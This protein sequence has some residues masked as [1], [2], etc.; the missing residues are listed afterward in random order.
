LRSEDLFEGGAMVGARRG[1]WT[2]AVIGALLVPMVCAAGPI[3]ASH[4]AGATVAPHDCTTNVVGAVDAAGQSATEDVTPTSDDGRYMA[5]VPR[6]N[7]A[8]GS[9]IAVI[10]RQTSQL[11]V[12][13]P[14]QPGTHAYVD[15][16]SG[17]GRFVLF[18]TIATDPI[19]GTDT[20]AMNLS[21]ADRTNH[22]VTPVAS[23]PDA[24]S[25]P[26]VYGAP[27]VSDDGSTVVLETWRSLLPVDTDQS[28]DVYRWRRGVGLDLVSTELDGMQSS[29]IAWWSTMSDD[30]RTIAFEWT[31]STP[32]NKVRVL[33]NG[34]T[35]SYTQV[36]GAAP[37][38]SGDGS[39]LFVKRSGSTVW[40]D[41]TTYDPPLPGQTPEHPAHDVGPNPGTW[42][43]S[44][45]VTQANHDGTEVVLDERG[46]DGSGEPQ[47][48]VR[49][50][51]TGSTLLVQ[52]HD[53]IWSYGVRFVGSTDLLAYAGTIVDP[54]T[55]IIT[56]PVQ[57]QLGDG[58]T[59]APISMRR[60]TSQPLQITGANF[61][62][63]MTVSLE[64]DVTV[65]NLSVVDDTHATVTIAAAPDASVGFRSLHVTATT[66]CDAVSDDVASIW[67]AAG[68]FHPLPPSRVLDTR[69]ST[70]GHPGALGPNS[71][72]DLKVTGVGGVPASAV[73]AVVLNVTAT[74]AT[75]EG[76]LTVWPSGSA[77]PNASN[78]N[79]SAGST[80][81]N[82]VT[83]KVGPNGSVS[84]YNA[85]GA[86][87]VIA[88]VVGWYSTTDG[89]MGSTLVPVDPYRALDSR[90]DWDQPYQAGGIAGLPLDGLPKGVTGV[91]LNVTVTDPQ[92]SGYA[93]V[94]PYDHNNPWAPR[95]LASNLNFT[96]GQTVPNMV[97]VPIDDFSPVPF[98]YATATTD[99]IVDVVGVFVD[100]TVWDGA[101]FQSSV[102][103]RIL[104]TR[105]ANGVPTTNP[106]GPDKTIHLQVSGRAG[107]PTDAIA[108]LVN[109][110][111][112]QPTGSGYITV[113]P[114]GEP[115]PVVSSLN[116]TPGLTAPNLVVVPIGPDGGIDLYNSSGN[117]HLIADVVGW[118]EG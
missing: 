7:G 84:I 116:F 12:V 59:R 9:R 106:V 102:P 41:L 63:G 50:V 92:S 117:S 111:V 2:C 31:D 32:A 56:S 26:G 30:G 17:D 20:G 55:P 78:L 22:T 89:P 88:D 72:F 69:T 105:F 91:V 68:Q 11:D 90:F 99:V 70:G 18:G 77:R 75:S 114:S 51:D 81:P 87:H 39:R 35:P 100:P 15:D 58:A 40:L 36:Y 83:S 85:V 25:A 104:D 49:D 115:R 57:A 80:R 118:Y 27:S 23:I 86:T 71:T 108:V 1:R 10:D 98:F 38:L 46:P 93:T 76:Y 14:S 74:Q 16:L 28:A 24:S 109:L 53:A 79:T 67:D 96:A 45:Y 97:I 8:V 6:V 34:A 48:W 101:S 103:S 54:T 52:G 73:D 21:V 62:P 82:L 61:R 107:V 29:T 66:G 113:W 43:D 112:T 110:T 60:G 47:L 3:V 5:Y 42:F 64:S 37:R 95:P 4:P 44:P 33:V 19:S 65:S 94:W 13:V